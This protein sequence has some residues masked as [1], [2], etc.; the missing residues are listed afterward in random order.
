MSPME[1]QHRLVSLAGTSKFTVTELCAD[2]QISRKTA[3]KWLR[4]YLGKR[5]PI[6]IIARYQTGLRHGL[7]PNHHD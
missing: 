5:P 4:R 6:L 1:Q 2:F 7:P 3:Y